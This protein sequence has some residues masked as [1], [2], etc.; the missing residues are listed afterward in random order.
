M[1]K[2]NLP[3]GFANI[4]NGIEL[5]PKA[6][7]R[8]STVKEMQVNDVSVPAE[9]SGENLPEFLQGKHYC[10]V[11]GAE[12]E[13]GENCTVSILAEQMKAAWRDAGLQPVIESK[14]TGKNKQ[15]VEILPPCTFSANGYNQ[16][17]HMI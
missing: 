11:S 5:L 16:T 8:T 1:E 17:W 13:S 15:D 2:I 12:V 6:L 14:G 10:I 7:G 4:L 9:F 3:Q